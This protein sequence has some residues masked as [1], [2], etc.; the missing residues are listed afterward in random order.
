M[1]S[2]ARAAITA[3]LLALSIPALSLEANAAEIQITQPWTRATPPA[4]KVGGGYLTLTNKGTVI[5]TLLGAS[6]EIADRVEVHK[7]EMVDG[8]MKMRPVPEGLEIPAGQTAELA[9][10]GYH[11]M[12]MGLKRPITQGER[13]PLTLKFEKSNPVDVELVAGPLGSSRPNGGENPNG[14]SSSMSHGESN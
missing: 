6:S 14:G 5:D 7:M 9:P 10:G 2:S 11:L 3:A 4:A 13:I 12:L 8:I 1:F